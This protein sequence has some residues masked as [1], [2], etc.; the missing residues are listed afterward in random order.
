MISYP[1]RWY[2]YIFSAAI[3]LFPQW[4]LTLHLKIQDRYNTSISIALV[5]WGKW[6]LCYLS[7]WSWFHLPLKICST[8]ESHWCFSWVS[9]GCV[10]YFPG[11]FLFL[12]F[13]FLG[14]PAMVRDMNEDSIVSFK[15]FLFVTM[16]LP[17]SS[18]LWRL[19]LRVA[20]DHLSGPYVW[21]N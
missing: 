5:I 6:Q 15:V 2:I 7:V 20:V 21:C 8:L 19:P 17:R 13:R 10:G 18:S 11:A 14:I 4:G 12:W 3:K 16:T 1:V 9:S